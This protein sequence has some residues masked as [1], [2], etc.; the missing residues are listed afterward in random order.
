MPQARKPG[1]YAERALSQTNGLLT[2]GLEQF[3]PGET[4]KVYLQD[5]TRPQRSTVLTD[6]VHS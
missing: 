1:W 2:L 3:L 5:E 6:T 4:P